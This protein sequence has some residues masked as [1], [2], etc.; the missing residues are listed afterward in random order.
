MQPTNRKFFVRDYRKE[1]NEAI[2]ELFAQGML[3]YLHLDHNKTAPHYP[4]LE[5]EVCVPL[6]PSSFICHMMQYM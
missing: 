6:I 2:K 3:E 4:I 5:K 1:D